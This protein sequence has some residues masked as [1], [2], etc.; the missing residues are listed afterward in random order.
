[1]KNMA[2]FV[3]TIIMIIGINFG[4][5]FCMI[6]FGNRFQYKDW[7]SNKNLF[8]KLYVTIAIIVTLPITIM[9][10]IF[11]ALFFIGNVIYNLGIKKDGE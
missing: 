11:D 1:M 5:A 4:A 9:I 10:Y 3:F 6:I 8:G 7:L 2:V